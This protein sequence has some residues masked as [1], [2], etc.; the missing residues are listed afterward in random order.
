MGEALGQGILELVK[1]EMVSPAWRRNLYRHPVK[2]L[3]PLSMASF[4][5][6]SNLALLL[7]LATIPPVE[8]AEIENHTLSGD[9]LARGNDIGFPE[10]VRPWDETSDVAL[11]PDGSRVVYVADDDYEGVQ[12]LFSAPVDGSEP[13]CKIHHDLAPPACTE[14]DVVSFAVTADSSHVLY[15]LG[16]EGASDG[17]LWVAPLVRTPLSAAPALLLS[18]KQFPDPTVAKFLLAPA[19][20]SGIQQLV[21][22]ARPASGERYRLYSIPLEN[23]VATDPSIE[24]GNGSV[25]SDAL[26]FP[27]VDRWQ[28]SPDGRWIAYAAVPRNGDGTPRMGIY[29]AEIGMPRSEVWLNQAA[30]FPGSSSGEV[31]LEIT[32]DS[33][34]IVYL[35]SEENPGG[36]D[37][38]L[39]VP[40]DGAQH[41]P[42]SAEPSSRSL[43]T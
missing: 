6:T 26:A 29:S 25:T 40:I 31:E 34:R 33:T 17:E 38:V 5:C 41:R 24:L 18:A 3:M 22:N 42:H 23:G 21:F 32:A 37:E 12:E 7:L 39:S 43:L 10:N 35:G 28:I 36:K 13:P 1:K 11:T 27:P 4:R 15:L 8:A 30:T 2:F 19:D 16:E 20:E 9:I 14:A